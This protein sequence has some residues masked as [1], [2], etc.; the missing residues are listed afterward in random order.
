MA[1]RSTF[2]PDTAGYHLARR[3]PTGTAEESVSD[4]LARLR[5]CRHDCVNALYVVD[6]AG[7]LQGY[8][9]MA[10]L[11]GAPGEARLASLMIAPA[12]RATPETDQE[13]IAILAVTHG[14]GAVPVVDASGRLLGA[15][16]PEALI[17]VLRREHV[18]DLHRLAGVTADETPVR[19]AMEASPLRRVRNRLPW[20]LLG[21][22]GSFLATA[23]MARFETTLQ[24]RLAVAFFVP[25]I[26]YLADAI[27]TQTEAITVRFLSHRHA[28]LMELLPR[29]LAVGV[30][31]GLALGALTLPVAW[32]VFGDPL[33]AWGVAL[34]I[35]TAGT[36][37]AAVGLALPWALSGLG[38]DPAFGSGPVATVIQD[39]LSLLIY[40][41]IT[42]LLLHLAAP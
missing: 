3:V 8:I 24:A 11:L 6:G 35:I 27:G 37:A 28:R 19:A 15:V 10:T 39:V 14:L 16:P 21:L 34:A 20:L 31:I 2:A 22:L 29:E 1:A 13:R 7:R 12:P 5:E 32:L 17:Q 40:F 36:T 26:V 25:A 18:E 23:I 33:L 9:R 42:T 30:L 41:R 4:A 38:M